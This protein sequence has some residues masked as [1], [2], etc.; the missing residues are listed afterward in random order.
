[1]ETVTEDAH[2]ALRMH[3][4]G[5]HSAYIGVPQASGLA[6]ES[7]SAHVGQRIRWA[8]G[9]AQIFR[10]DNPLLGRGLS[11]MQRLCYASAMLHFFYGLPRLVFLTAPVGFLLFGA[12][13]FNARPTVVLAYA[14]PHMAHMVLTSSR[15]NGRWRHS[16][17]AEVYEAVL[18][19]YVVIPTTLALILPRVGLFKVTAKGG[20][21]EKDHFD[22]RIAGPYLFLLTVNLVAFGAGLW[23]LHAHPEA[24]DVI[25]INLAWC[26]YDLLILGAA[27]A[28]ARERR[29]VRGT[30]RVPVAEPAVL[31]L[32]G[33]RTL[34]ATTR[35]LSRGGAALR[36]A[37]PCAIRAGERL[38][39]GFFV[40]GVERPVPA[41]VV[42]A[43]DGLLRVR[44][45]PG[46]HHHEAWIV[47]ALFGR[48][49]VW[50]R[51]WTGRERDRPLRALGRIA[52]HALGL[53]RRRAA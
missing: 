34:A 40:D 8:R 13:I 53:G 30:W 36:L 25:L 11:P 21:V 20:K 19:A 23:R 24:L 48:A 17:W 3:R 39:V 50:A 41:R 46:S 31:R 5:W 16:F 28:V 43:A 52:A 45:E 7:L 9:M 47:R 29:Q 42:Q 37:S 44:F 27:L 32:P 10:I 33:E 38:T 18:A 1:V 51:G 4:R 15:L 35:D 49:D 26:A 12:H 14:L 6:T 22:R 2:T